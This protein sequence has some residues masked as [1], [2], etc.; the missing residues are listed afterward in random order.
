[1]WLLHITMTFLSKNEKNGLVKTLKW[2][3]STDVHV[4][5][6]HVRVHVDT[7][8]RTCGYVLMYIN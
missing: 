5:N 7:R 6:G 1:M 8:M 2:I 3:F 4:D